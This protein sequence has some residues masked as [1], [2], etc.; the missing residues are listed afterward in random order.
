M[1]ENKSIA[2]H[3][4]YTG[5]SSPVRQTKTRKAGGLNRRSNCTG[6]KNGTGLL[7]SKTAVNAGGGYEPQ[8]GRPREGEKEQTEDRTGKGTTIRTEEGGG[9]WANRGV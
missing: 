1:Q 2:R 7:E 3:Q 5:T 8:Q 4:E 9:M 6:K